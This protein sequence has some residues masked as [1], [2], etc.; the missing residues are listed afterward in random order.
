MCDVRKLLKWCS[1]YLVKDMGLTMEQQ[2][3]IIKKSRTKRYRTDHQS[4]TRIICSRQT[5]HVIFRVLLGIN[6]GQKEV[7]DFT[8][9]LRMILCKP[10]LEAWRLFRAHL[11]DSILPELIPHSIACLG[12]A[13]LMYRGSFVRTCKRSRH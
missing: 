12:F 10:L 9:L 11:Q 1:P 3:K 2:K 4:Y 5:H 7:S 8:L 6:S 13:P